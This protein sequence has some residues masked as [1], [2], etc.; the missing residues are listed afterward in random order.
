MQSA[1]S[2]YKTS[3]SQQL[4]NRG[5]IYAIISITNDEVQSKISVNTNATTTAYWGNNEIFD[6]DYVVKPYATCEPDFTKIDGTMYFVPEEDSDSFYDNGFVSSDI[7]DAIQFNFSE[8]VDIDGLTID[9]GECY[10]SQFRLGYNDGTTKTVIYE[11]NQKIF[12]CDDEF[13]NVTWAKITPL[14][15]ADNGESYEERRLRIYNILFSKSLV[16]EN[17]VVVDYTHV[18]N[19]S[20]ISEDLPSTDMT[21]NIANYDYEYDI[22]DDDNIVNQFKINDKIRVFHGYDITGTESIEWVTPFTFYLKEITI[23]ETSMTITA[24][25]I[26][27]ERYTDTFYNG[28]WYGSS[29]GI[30]LAEAAEEVAEDAGIADYDFD[31]T[32]LNGITLFNPIPAVTHKEALQLIANMACSI[33]VQDRS[34]KVCIKSLPSTS[35]SLTRDCELTSAPTATLTDAIK[36]IEVPYTNY[37]LPTYAD[38]T[39]SMYGTLDAG[40][41]IAY[42]DV[43]LDSD[44]AAIV[45]GMTI[46]GSYYYLPSK[47]VPLGSTN[48][49]G[50]IPGSSQTYTLSPQVVLH[51]VSTL[52]NTYNQYANFVVTLELYDV[53]QTYTATLNSTDNTYM[54][55]M[56]NP[57]CGMG[58]VITKIADSDG[59]DVTDDYSLTYSIT[60]DEK[61]AYRTDIEF[62]GLPS[63]DVDVSFTLVGK[64]YIDTTQTYTIDVNEDGDDTLTWENPLLNTSGNAD[65]VAEM[66]YDYY[67]KPIEYSIEWRGDP[68]I[69]AGD[70]IYLELKSGGKSQIAI[71]KNTLSFNGAWSGQITAKKRS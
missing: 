9:F 65:L 37:T 31:T 56:S 51:D 10:P 23:N 69:D 11:N 38:K 25:D 50:A 71:E 49:D 59:N 34:G 54:A 28:K 1:S 67:K 4:R 8:A 64:N 45:T 18:E 21:L 63:T 62:D 15:F 48:L 35:Y 43:D 36:Q 5:Y 2:T 30:S 16:F 61:L 46:T 7:G 53:I 27:N 47:H 22:E 19:I 66:L 24:S 57:A 6:N 20:L 60:S 40:T 44:M 29:D 17:D 33:L 26:Y 3:M 52:Y 32:A 41:S 68:I 13:T 14:A 12:T 58:I 42:F 39:I 55:V 70:R